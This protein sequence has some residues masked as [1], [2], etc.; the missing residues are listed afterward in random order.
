VRFN[1]KEPLKYNDMSNN[2]LEWMIHTPNLLNEIVSN[3]NQP[4]IE[5]PIRILGNMLYR[6]G[7]IAARINDP[8]LNEIMIRLTIYDIA[9]PESENYDW[10]KCREIL[11]F[12]NLKKP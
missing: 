6:L 10:N 1:L 8:E 4:A 2:E 9:N 7:E 12:K 11:G 3:S 5:A